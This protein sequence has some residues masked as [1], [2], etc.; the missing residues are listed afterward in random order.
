MW[1][2]TILLCILNILFHFN[3]FSIIHCICAFFS[4][5]CIQDYHELFSF[6]HHFMGRRSVLTVDL[7]NLTIWFFSFLIKSRTFTLMKIKH[8]PAFLLCVYELLTSLFL[9]FAA[10][11]RVKE[12]L[13]TQPLW[14]SDSGSN[15][16][17]WV[18]S[19]QQ[20]EYAGQ[21]GD[22]LRGRHSGRL[23]FIMLPQ[24]GL[25]LKLTI[26]AVFH[27]MVLDYSRP[28]ITETMKVKSQIRGDYCIFCNLYSDGET[29]LAVHYS[30]HKHTPN[31]LCY[32][33]ETNVVIYVNYTLKIYIHIYF[34][35]KTQH[36]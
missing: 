8:F 27:F 5:R 6:L 23:D 36:N 21:R 29:R 12:G 1:S 18:L 14:Y 24:N 11:I 30:Q 15:T 26:Y 25:H 13:W 31:Q 17:R 35:T 7:S 33:P 9:H 16:R 3:Y 34:S 2:L 20:A 19:D 32:R 10:F 28:Q 22:S 4:L